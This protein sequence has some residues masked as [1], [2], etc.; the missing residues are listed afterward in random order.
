MK[1]L[2]LKNKIIALFVMSLLITVVA[3]FFSVKFVIGDYINK[4]YDSRMVSN[5]NLISSEIKQSLERDISVIESLD[6]GI[7]GIRDTQQKL[8][9]EQVV[10]LI[11]K[12]A[13]S[14]KGSLNK[15][16]SQYFIDLARDHEEGIKLTQIFSETGQAKVI[17]SKKKNGVVDFFTIDLSLIDGLIKR[18][19]IPGVYFELL[20]GQSNTIYS[21][22][23]EN[24]DLKKIDIITVADSK[25]YLRSYIDY[26]Y[27]DSITG[28]INQDITKYMSLCAF[29]MLVVSLLTL[30]IQLNPLSKLK[31]LVESLAGSDADLT[32]RIE[33]NRKDEIGDISKS[34]NIFIDNLQSLFLNIASSNRSL[35]DAREELDIHI[36]RNVSTV[37]RYNAQSKS[38]SEAIDDIRQ[39][40]LDVQEQIKQ[41]MELAEQVSYQVR[42]T[43]QKGS[44]VEKIVITLSDD[45]EKISSLI[46]GMD[47]VTKGISNI[48]NTIQKI[49]DQTDLLALNASIEA[50]RAGEAGKGFAVVAEEVRVLASRTRSSTTE[51]D[52]FLDQFS[53]SSDQIVSQMSQVLKNSELNRNSTL[54]VINQIQLVEKVVGQINMINSSISIAADNQC[55]NMDKLNAEIQLT[56]NLSDE[57]T[58]SASSIARVHGDIGQVSSALTK[59]VSIFKV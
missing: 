2:S 23:K 25:W 49:A 21:T 52:E 9:Y 3:A 12:T 38:L 46:G 57:I 5:V 56:N 43:S 10:K 22:G 20:D 36:G 31:I 50:A 40:S 32:Q 37:A 53:S 29:M 6:F 42:E 14:D 15:E 41:S 13:L 11:N 24:L 28:R 54:D 39:S 19:S 8:G 7:I 16:Q 26:S 48:L 17:V 58:D 51:I 47:T 59:D 18:Y 27:I 30:N 1:P 33:L 45:T 35:N 34:V 55:T 44:F 4:S